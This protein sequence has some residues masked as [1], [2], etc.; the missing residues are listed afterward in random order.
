VRIAVDSSVLLD[1]LA[2]DP[3]FGPASREALRRAY[4]AGVLTACDVVWGEVRAHFQE[5]ATFGEALATLGV[6]YEPLRQ[7][8]AALAGERWREYCLAIRRRR[9]RDRLVAD[10]LIGAHAQVQAEALLS[11]DRGFFRSYFQRL[12]LIDPTEP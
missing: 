10:F 8:A 2:G 5:E 11:R 1:V 7:E 3:Q 6:V 12:R 4:D 9:D